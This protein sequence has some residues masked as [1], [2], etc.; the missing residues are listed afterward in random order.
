MGE[1][2][3]AY[4]LLAGKSEERNHYEEQG[5]GSWII[6]EWILEGKDEEVWTGLVWAGIRTS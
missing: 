6:L 5:V 3:N 1:E 4:R 2:R